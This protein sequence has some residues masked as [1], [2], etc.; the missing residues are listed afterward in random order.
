[1]AQIQALVRPSDPLDELR[2]RL[3]SG[4]TQADQFWHTTLRNLAARF[5]VQGQPQQRRTLV[6]PRIHWAEASNLWQNVAI[7]RTRHM[8]VSLWQKLM[9]S[10][11]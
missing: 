9:Q 5:G 7:R 10:F 4:H 8:P 3:G 1:V 2:C 6:D 11:T